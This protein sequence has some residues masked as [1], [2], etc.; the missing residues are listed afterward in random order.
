M[1]LNPPRLRPLV[2]SL[3][4]ALLAVAALMRPGFARAA[5]ATGFFDQTFGDFAEE[6]KN[7]KA[8]GKQGVLLMF[9]ME[10]CPY[11]E[12]MKTTVLN[13]PEVQAYFKEHFLS[14][15]LDLEGAVGVT[16]FTGGHM[17][18]KDLGRVRYQVRAT[19]TFAF[20]DLQGNLIARY[21][22]AT[23]DAQEFLWLGEYVVSGRYE[24]TPFPRYRR[25]RQDAAAKPGAGS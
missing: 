13:R 14:F 11:C 24:D 12:R 25:E 9:Q 19:P 10:G 8:Q 6:L 21:T 17:T 1:I 16:D 7:A 23:G 18:E 15:P 4:L 5:D 3:L 20:F 22:G 2:G